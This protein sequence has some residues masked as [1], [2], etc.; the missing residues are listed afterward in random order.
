MAEPKTYTGGCHCGN[1]RY[2][3]TGAAFTP[4]GRDPLDGGLLIVPVVVHPEPDPLVR[5]VV[6]D[7]PGLTKLFLEP[8]G[9]GT[10][11]PQRLRVFRG[12]R[13]DA[14]SRVQRHEQNPAMSPEGPEYYA[15][16]L[17]ELHEFVP[18]GIQ[19]EPRR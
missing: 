11:R 2:E 14:E 4:N 3:V 18:V 5:R 13:V 10:E 16:F 9:G 7:R 12:E 1:V 19:E 8:L 15:D 17:H 6:V